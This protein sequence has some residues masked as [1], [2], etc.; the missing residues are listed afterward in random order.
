MPSP[1][2]HWPRPH[3]MSRLSIKSIYTYIKMIYEG[4]IN[5]CKINNCTRS[6]LKFKNFL[7]QYTS[8][9]YISFP[10][11]NDVCV[12]V[13]MCVC[14]HACYICMYV[15]PCLQAAVM[16]WHT[17]A[18]HKPYKPIVLFQCWWGKRKI[19]YLKQDLQNWWQHSNWGPIITVTIFSGN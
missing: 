8:Y 17:C 16:P 7:G 12:Y 10:I 6:N 5:N 13:C 1:P 15:P 4:K 14:M 18:H 3:P 2:A 11:H 19:E 9:S